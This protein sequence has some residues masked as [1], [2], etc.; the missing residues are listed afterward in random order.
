[1]PG[2]Y[3]Y[4]ALAEHELEGWA[5][6]LGATPQRPTRDETG[7]DWLVEFPGTDLKGPRDKAP[8]ALRCYFQVKSTVKDPASVA[9]KLSALKHLCDLAE[10]AFVLIVQKDKEGGTKRAWLV[11][12][13]STLMGRVLRRCRELSVNE[14]EQLPNRVHLVLRGSDQQELRPP[15]PGSLWSA[16]TAHVGNG[17]EAYRI[18]KAQW[19]KTLGYEDGEL[20]FVVHARHKSLEEAESAL[21]DTMLGLRRLDFSSSE[22]YDPRFGLRVRLEGMPG[23]P[24]CLMVTPRSLE[25]VWVS[26][27]EGGDDGTAFVLEGEVAGP[28]GL[29]RLVSS[30]Q[31]S[32]R[33]AMKLRVAI[34]TLEERYLDLVLDLAQGQLDFQVHEDFFRAEPRSLSEWFQF[35]KLLNALLSD[36]SLSVSVHGRRGDYGQ[37]EAPSAPVDNPEARYVA[38]T[39]ARLESFVGDVVQYRQLAMSWSDVLRA[40]ASLEHLDQLVNDPETVGLIFSPEASTRG[41]DSGMA[42]ICIVA[43]GDHAVFRPV[44]I[45]GTIVLEPLPGAP[46]S[47][48]SF[49]CTSVKLGDP[50]FRRRDDL[51]IEA[52]SR[53]LMTYA[54]K[55]ADAVGRSSWI[56]MEDP[57]FDTRADPA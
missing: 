47:T 43:L 37:G 2:P 15:G 30:G 50:D 51:P 52:R 10:P 44:A 57:L 41:G 27:R 53:I 14:V 28:G 11:P 23:G 18:S 39:V 33:A 38:A 24:G 6:E 48:L 17:V 31:L 9:V 34:P 26:I 46:P 35:G 8:P 21:V 7:W 13:D 16:I 22:H 56:I 36:Q 25:A 42:T 45:V 4:A 29:S 54:A 20:E 5:L 3:Q 12:V 40:G 32:R 19:R 55:V 49:L 1:M